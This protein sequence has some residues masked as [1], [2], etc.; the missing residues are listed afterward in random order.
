MAKRTLTALALFLIGFPLLMVG[1]LPY[2]L[3]I[4]FLLVA[5]SWEYMN[6]M[7]A[8]EVQTPRV[9]L[10][11]LVLVLIV[12]RAFFE[13]AAATTLTLA[14]MALMAWHLWQY[15]QGRERA[16]TDFGVSVSILVYIGWVGSYLVLLRGLPNGG[17]W[18]IL[19]LFCVWMADTGGY[20]IGSA[21]GKHK[22][23]PRL[24]PHKSWEGYIAGLFSAVLIG[25]YLAFCFT[26][27][28][29]LNLQIWQGALLGL[30]VGT[31]SPLGDL[32]KSMIKR[33]AGFK[34]S[35][36]LIPGHGGAFDRIDSWIWASVIGYLVIGGWLL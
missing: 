30:L 7:R 27:W 32:G 22:M 31:L 33:M 26:M 20:M 1:G 25:A 3:F 9:F 8:V 19:S 2:F 13:A 11:A 6:M 12:V 14:V 4:G 36:N 28:G 17:W 10:L 35:G 18:L 34:D 24:S 15:E 21:Y 5:A 16:A 29:P 23:S